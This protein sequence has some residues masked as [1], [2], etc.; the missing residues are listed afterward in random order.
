MIAN[1]VY[2]QCIV[3][4]LTI[5][6]A[7]SMTGGSL[8]YEMIKIPGASHVISGSLI[9]Y[10]IEQKIKLLDLSKT[11]IDEFGVV[12]EHVAVSMA[13]SVRTQLKSDMGVGVTG[14]AGPDKQ[15]FTSHLEAWIAIDDQGEISTYQLTFDQLSRFKA[16]RKTVEFVYQ[17]LNLI[18]LKKQF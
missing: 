5:A 3:N 12:S 4:G 15:A 17:Q 8:A 6:F 1:K 16:I 10:S 7:E 18:L 2:H 13:K 9:A 11:E 14:N